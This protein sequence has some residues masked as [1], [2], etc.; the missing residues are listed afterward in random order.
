M[1]DSHYA[2]ENQ[3][4]CDRLCGMWLHEDPIWGYIG[5]SDCYSFDSDETKEE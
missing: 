3:K 1:A 5:W 4:E 2:L